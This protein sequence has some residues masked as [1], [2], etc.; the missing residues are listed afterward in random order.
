M[1][2]NRIPGLGPSDSNKPIDRQSQREAAQRI[3][4]V[5]EVDPDEQA[6]QRRF[7]EIMQSNAEEDEEKN[8]AQLPSPFDLSG[9]RDSS[10][11][12]F[13]MDEIPS[14]S[15]SQPPTL[16]PSAQGA[17]SD[18][19]LPQ[20]DQFWQETD[21]PDQPPGK[22]QF[23][24]K[25]GKA[26][27]S[28]AKKMEPKTSLF[29]LPGKGGAKGEGA[30]KMGSS[31]KKPPAEET[32]SGRYWNPETELSGGRPGFTS[33]ESKKKAKKD[34]LS[35]LNAP[36]TS[37]D[38][39]E[40]QTPGKVSTDRFASVLQKAQKD[41]SDQEKKQGGKKK[42]EIQII[43]PSMPEL[44]AWVQ[45]SAIAATQAAASYLRPEAVSLFY[46]MVGSIGVM[47]APPGISRTELTL[48]NPAF[49]NSKFFGAT[50]ELIKYSTA[51]DSY[52]IRLSGSN[53]AVAAFNQ[54]LGGLT[55]AFQTGHFSFRIGRIDAE[56]SV[57]RPVLR[58]KESRED[59][60]GGQSKQDKRRQ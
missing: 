32:P 43:S 11:S 14:S 4:K 7:Q 2:A 51:P 17:K 58:R 31:K 39:S 30:S 42:E 23:Q 50:I 5:G 38:K 1:N 37:E 21:L 41:K 56:Y 27:S 20:S 54:N 49:A 22:P 6:R 16:S 26:G 48:N 34:S 57:D 35:A 53:E 59:E 10:S 52:N 9:A 12:D 46:Q 3:E 24:E 60:G 36:E 45:P 29:G 28:G 25:T 40:D 47:S 18:E 33:D 19:D 13:G 55:A 8:S 44:P 15:Y